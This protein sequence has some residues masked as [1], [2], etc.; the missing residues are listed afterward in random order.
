M[1]TGVCSKITLSES[2]ARLNAIVVGRSNVYSYVVLLKFCKA[3]PFIS[4]SV[5]SQLLSIFGLLSKMVYVAVVP[6]SAVTVNTPLFKSTT[7]PS[8]FFSNEIVG[9]LSAVMVYS[10]TVGSNVIP[11]AA[12]VASSVSFDNWLTI[13][14]V[15]GLAT[16]FFSDCTLMV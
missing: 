10:L 15:Y 1:Y 11:S 14:I 7:C 9:I 3:N 2:T 4:I 16:P 6:S 5:N 8:I 12:M 13:L